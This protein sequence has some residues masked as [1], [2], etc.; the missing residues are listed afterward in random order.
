MNRVPLEIF[1]LDILIK[2]D[3]KFNEMI[4]KSFFECPTESDLPEARQALGC[5]VATL[6]SCH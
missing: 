4:D 3:E 2:I 5:K 6:P 1:S